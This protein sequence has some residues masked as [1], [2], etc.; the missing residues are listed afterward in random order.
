[1]V[2]CMMNITAPS[3]RRV[4]IAAVAALIAVA[5]APAAL[6]ARPR[7]TSF[8]AKDEGARIVL[9]AN[10]CVSPREVGNNMS[11]TFRIF[12]GADRS[13]F[14]PLVNERVSGI[15][16]RR[17]MAAWARLPDFWLGRGDYWVTVV[18]R[19]RI[20]DETARLAPRFLRIT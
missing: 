5:A 6:D 14:F 10:F 8:Y 9:R 19:N 13:G 1:M 12:G 7:I 2:R 15:A 18:V 16:W 3:L 20:T 11:V 4:R 17:C